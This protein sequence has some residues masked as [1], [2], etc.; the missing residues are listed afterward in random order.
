MADILKLMVKAL[1]YHEIL[2]I[3]LISNEIN[4]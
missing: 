3:P 4:T 2:K 1:I